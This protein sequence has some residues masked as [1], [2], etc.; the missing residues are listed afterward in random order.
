M[1]LTSKLGFLAERIKLAMSSYYLDLLCILPQEEVEEF[2]IGFVRTLIKEGLSKK[3][4]KKGDLFL[5]VF[6]EDMDSDF[7]QLEC[8][9]REWRLQEGLEEDKQWS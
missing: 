4:I 2:G 3:E 8:M 6:Q 1:Y 7:G 9:R 5:G